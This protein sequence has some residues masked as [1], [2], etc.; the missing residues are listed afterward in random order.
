[1][2]D[3]NVGIAKLFDSMRQGKSTRTK[4]TETLDLMR[5]KIASGLTY[6]ATSS[7]QASHELMLRC[8]ILT[9]IELITQ[10]REVDGPQHQA[11]LKLLERRLEVLGAY[12]YDKQ[13]VL[14][15]RR[16]AMQLSQ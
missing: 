4:F 1:M 11:T 6:T 2:E 12:V 13:Y 5:K 15:I 3:F 14:S 8:H 9:D 10:E 7:L 16:A